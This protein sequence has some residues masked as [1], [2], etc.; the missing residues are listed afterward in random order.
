MTPSVRMAIGLGVSLL[1]AAVPLAG[2]SPLALRVTPAVSRAPAFVRVHV[3]VATHEDNRALDVVADSPNYYRASRVPLEG[4]A[5]ARLQIV[6][7]PHLPS[8]TYTVQATLVGS[9]GPRATAST[10]IA[11]APSLL[12]R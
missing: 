12:E 3:T 8:G 5:A 6:E 9:G 4:E 7:F 11:V 10:T 1:A 2:D